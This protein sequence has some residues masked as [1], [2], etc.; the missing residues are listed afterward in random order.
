MAAG[1]GSNTSLTVAVGQV[2]FAIGDV[3]TKLEIIDGLVSDAA[4]AGARW[5]T[6][7]VKVAATVPYLTDRRPKL[8]SWFCEPSPPSL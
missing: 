3:D 4:A 2:A 6:S 7:R 5:W 1:T 8:Y